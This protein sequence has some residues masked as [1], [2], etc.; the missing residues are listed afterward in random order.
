MVDITIQPSKQNE[1]FIF[2]AITRRARNLMGI[3]VKLMPIDYIIDLPIDFNYE[4][5]PAKWALH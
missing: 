2:R 3:K 4:F 5:I 1:V